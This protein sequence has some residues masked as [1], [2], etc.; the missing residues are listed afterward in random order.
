MAVN[1]IIS[2]AWAADQFVGADATGVDG[3]AAV[4]RTGLR[5]VLILDAAALS[6]P[7][8]SSASHVGAQRPRSP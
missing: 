4:P 7:V 1:Q 5:P 3:S 6:T 8:A 2:W